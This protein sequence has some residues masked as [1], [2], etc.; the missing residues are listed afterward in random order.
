MK[1][2]NHRQKYGRTTGEEG[3]DEWLEDRLDRVFNSPSFD[4]EALSDYGFDP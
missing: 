1:S 2:H 4:G 3:E